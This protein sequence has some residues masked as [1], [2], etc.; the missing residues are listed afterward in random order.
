VREPERVSRLGLIGI[1]LTVFAVG[2]A[3]AYP[4]LTRTPLVR[5]DFDGRVV[6]KFVTL[7]ESR[8]GS[9]TFPLLVVEIANG[10]RF[11]VAVSDEQYER[12]RV[13]MRVS[14]HR[15][16]LILSW[17]EPRMGAPPGAGDTMEAR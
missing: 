11:N 10:A 7:G 17:D 2:F 9:A 5:R 12:A 15:G 6:E 14:R 3:Y 1:A 16:E 13:G 4:R 8:M